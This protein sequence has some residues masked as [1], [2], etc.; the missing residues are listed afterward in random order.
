M[1]ALP[2]SPFIPVSPGVFQG[3]LPSGEIEPS[4]MLACAPGESESS[5]SRGGREEI[6]AVMPHMAA[7]DSDAT[8][9]IH[10]IFYHARL[11]IAEDNAAH[12]RFVL[13]QATFMEAIE[14]P[15][16]FLRTA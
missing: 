8:D 12:R 11:L 4:V 7:G 1:T 13:D 2:P 3:S 9:H 5:T 6:P 14:E 10:E 16:L 15:P